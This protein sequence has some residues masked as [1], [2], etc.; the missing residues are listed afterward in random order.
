MTSSVTINRDRK[1][2]VAEPDRPVTTEEF[3]HAVN[4]TFIFE[5]TLNDV[6]QDFWK[7]NP[8]RLPCLYD[9]HPFDGPIYSIPIEYKHRL[10]MFV[11]RNVFCSPHCAKKYMLVTRDFPTKCYGLFSFMM[12]SVYG[13]GGDVPPASDVELLIYSG[14]DIEKWRELPKQAVYIRLLPK[15]IHP[16]EMANRNVVAHPLSVHPAFEKIMR[17]NQQQM[18]CSTMPDDTPKPE[19][20]E[21]VA[22]AEEDAEEEDEDIEEEEAD[23]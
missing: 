22:A 2:V 13:Y 20:A 15:E 18:E 4:Y 1:N 16:F 9:H 8:K 7:S 19:L 12:R 14:M 17:W 10:K 11:V 23:S 21:A 5:S 3:N 6:P